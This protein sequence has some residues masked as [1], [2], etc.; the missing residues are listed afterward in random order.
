VGRPTLNLGHT[1][2]GHKT[3]CKKEDVAF[4]LVELT[5]VGRFIYPATK[6][7][8]HWHDGLNILSQGKALLGGVALL[9]WVWPCWRK[10]I[11]CGGRL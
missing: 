5:P 2:C 11:K 1:L 4:C 10:C 7:V 8:F 6:A 3:A 9:E